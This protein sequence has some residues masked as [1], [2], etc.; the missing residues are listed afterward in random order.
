MRL[1]GI[2]TEIGRKDLAEEALWRHLDEIRY[3][4]RLNNQKVLAK[5]QSTRSG[6]RD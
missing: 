5:L 3:K 4:N 6:I 2:K 1:E